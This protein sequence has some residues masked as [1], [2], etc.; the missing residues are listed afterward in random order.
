L[1][2]LLVARPA[3]R[4]GGLLC[5]SVF[6]TQEVFP[7]IQL[8][9][10]GGTQMKI[11]KMSLSLALIV[12]TAGLTAQAAPYD[13]GQNDGRLIGKEIKSVQQPRA[14]AS[15]E[16]MR[17]L[18]VLVGDWGFDIK[19]WQDAARAPESMKGTTSFRYILGGSSLQGHYKGDIAGSLFEG[20]L[21]ISYDDIAQQYVATW[22]HSYDPN[23]EARYT[24]QASLDA[25]GNLSTLTLTADTC[26]DCGDVAT[27][28][29]SNSA[30]SCTLTMTVANHNTLTEQMHS[31]DKAGN[32]FKSEDATYGRIQATPVPVSVVVKK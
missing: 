27:A 13:S 26:Q 18:N 31:P 9:F 32:I 24:G 23:I 2:L 3:Q 21:T 5:I 4:V 8:D 12:L 11:R 17:A 6:T 19:I 7:V 25:N 10:K 28:N 14:S 1:R 20:F 16:S 29:P 30:A 15:R 22:K